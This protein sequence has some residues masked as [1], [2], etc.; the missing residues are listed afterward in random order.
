M[1][2][3]PFHIQEQCTIFQVRVT[4]APKYILIFCLAPKLTKYTP[5]ITNHES[6]PK[7]KKYTPQFLSAPSVG[8]Q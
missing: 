8:P 2:C 5:E 3:V 6:R 1:L 4:E 7:L